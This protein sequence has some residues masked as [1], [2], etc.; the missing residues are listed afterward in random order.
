MDEIFAGVV[1]CCAILFS[2]TKTWTIHATYSSESL[3]ATSIFSHS[4]SNKDCEIRIRS[5]FDDPIDLGNEKI[6]NLN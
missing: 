1:G 3:L 6:A 2:S 4:T 5:E